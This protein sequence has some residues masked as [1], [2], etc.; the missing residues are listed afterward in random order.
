MEIPQNAS[1]KLLVSLCSLLRSWYTHACPLAPALQ[2]QV[3]SQAQEYSHILL[4]AG[5]KG[6]YD[7]IRTQG[8]IRFPPDRLDTVADKISV[9][10]QAELAGLPLND[11]VRAQGQKL[12]I[13]PN[14]DIRLIMEH[15]PKM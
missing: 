1:L 12:S 2:V 9:I 6:L 5:E 11:M 13:N 10:L 14:S 3:I 15:A 8:G 7:A 4:R